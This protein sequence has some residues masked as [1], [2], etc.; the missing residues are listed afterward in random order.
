MSSRT[1][2]TNSIAIFHLFAILVTQSS[3]SSQPDW[4]GK[5][6]PLAISHLELTSGSVTIWTL[7][8]SEVTVP[9]LP[10]T[11]GVASASGSCQLRGRDVQMLPNN[12]TNGDLALVCSTSVDWAHWMCAF[13]LGGKIVDPR[14][15]ETDTTQSVSVWAGCQAGEA[16]NI[17]GTVAKITVAEATGSVADYPA[18]VTP[19]F[20]R[21]YTVE[22]DT[23]AVDCNNTTLPAGCPICEEFERIR[24]SFTIEQ[25]AAS[26]TYKNRICICE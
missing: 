6:C 9:I 4:C 2:L 23:G 24:V 1:S 17:A 8:G 14:Q 12:K 20:K 18:M 10:E 25:T 15:F 7:D 16:N 19:D 3:C 11:G 21:N 26:Y 13:V 5:N 22:I